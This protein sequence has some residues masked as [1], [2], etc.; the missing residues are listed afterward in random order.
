MEFAA[1][2]VNIILIFI[3]ARSIITLF[4]RGRG[5]PTK[6]KSVASEET[7]SVV[8]EVVREL[9]KDEVC[10]RSI[11]KEEAHIIVKEDVKHYFCSWDCREKFLNNSI[12]TQ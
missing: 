2:L 3:I 1:G 9:V 5:V 7:K 4:Y 12:K 11:P 6:A 8:K 10:N